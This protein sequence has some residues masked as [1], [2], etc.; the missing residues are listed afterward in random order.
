MGIKQILEQVWKGFGKK[1]LLGGPQVCLFY[2]KIYRLRE[3]V[4]NVT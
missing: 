3:K 4:T 2:A 1:P